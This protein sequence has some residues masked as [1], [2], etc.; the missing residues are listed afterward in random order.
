LSLNGLFVIKKKK[1]NED[2]T[3]SLWCLY[4]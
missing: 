3:T 4:L 2:V 1:N